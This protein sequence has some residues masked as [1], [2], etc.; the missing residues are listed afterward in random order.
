MKLKT[1]HQFFW[2]EIQ[3]NKLSKELA[4]ILVDI[5]FAGKIL[6]TQ[7]ENNSLTSSPVISTSINHHGENQHKLDALSHEIF[8][9]TLK[10][11]NLCKNLVSEEVEEKIILSSLECKGSFD[12]YIDPLDGTSNLDSN[13][14]VGTIFSIYHSSKGPN[15]KNSLIKGRSQVA[16]GYLIYGTT[17]MLVLTIGQGVHGFTYD[18]N[19]GEFLLTHS[20]IRIS[21][22]GSTYSI[23]EGNCEDFPYQIR[24]YLNFCK[25]EDAE[26]KLP[27]KAR[28][29]GS[30]VADIHRILFNGGIFLYPSTRK[31]P[32]GKLRLMYECN[33]IAFIIEQAG[34]LAIDGM[35]AIL[36]VKCTNHHQK[37]PFIA[38][39]Y[40][41]VKNVLNLYKNES[42]SNH[43]FYSC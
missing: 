3:D 5:T 16:A 37:T 29:I 26:N 25:Q 19:L 2:Q 27:Y 38:G 15:L 24:N 30:M 7:I 4:K 22:S 9:D 31:Y 6:R 34:G 33:P 36:D 14:S 28:Y 21:K 39:S 12:V 42:I 35:G 8:Y 43:L 32:K 41:M 10:E 40:N 23:N 17:T 11:S 1:L 18:R 20:K 13:V